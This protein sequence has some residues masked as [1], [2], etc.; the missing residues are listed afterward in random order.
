MRVQQKE[1]SENE[2]VGGKSYK[3]PFLNSLFLKF[4]NYHEHYN[5]SLVIWDT[6][7]NCQSNYGFNLKTYL[8]V[9]EYIKSMHTFG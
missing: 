1:Y 7:C 2:T 3:I 9:I 4:L 6:D 5:M 8:V